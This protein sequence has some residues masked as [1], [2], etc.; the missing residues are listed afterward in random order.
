MLLSLF[1]E[2]AESF[3]ALRVANFS[4]NQAIKKLPN[5]RSLRNKLKYKIASATYSAH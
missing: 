5:S 3:P 1:R 2:R 4:T